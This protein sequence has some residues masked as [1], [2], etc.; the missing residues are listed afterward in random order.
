MMA[1]PSEVEEDIPG[2]VT[3]E[4]PSKNC[5]GNVILLLNYKAEDEDIM[6]HSSRESLITLTVPPG[7]SNNI[8]NHDE[9]SPDQNSEEN[10]MLSLTYKAEDEDI[11]PCSSRENLITLNVHP[12]LHSTALSHNSSNH[13]EPSSNQLQIVTTSTGQK[14]GKRYQCGKKLKNTSSFS[15]HGRIHARERRYCCSE[16]GKC[17]TKKSHLVTHE[18]IHT[19]EKPYSCSECGKCFRDKSHFV[20]HERSHTGERPYSCSECFKCYS[21]SSSLVRHQR[22]HTGEKPFACLE[23]LKCF[24]V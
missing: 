12:G 1:D 2:D 13:E 16:C 4:N 24:S 23:C 10:I 18:R 6:L 9:L 17:F 22:V 11:M 15:T 21:V 8:P 3:T 7:L 5:N 19:G 20:R 14:G